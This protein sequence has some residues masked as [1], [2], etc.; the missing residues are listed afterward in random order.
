MQANRHRFV[1]LDRDGVIN[2]DSPAYIKNRDEFEFL[3]GSLQALK[4]L[5][6]AGFR[7]I[8][9]TNQSAVGRRLMTL[10]ELQAIHDKM[11]AAVRQH[12]GRIHDI[13]FCPHHPADACRCRKP[14]PGLIHRAVQKHAIDLSR[15]TMVGDSVKDIECA[16][17]AGCGR[18]VLVRTGNG[19]Q[20]EK[21]LRERGI[22]VEHVARDLDE[23][24]GWLIAQALESPD[25]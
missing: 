23:A 6:R 8:V 25:A 12:G 18:A 9:V 14:Q 7:L 20:A 4:N 19:I 22:A 17:N 15:A 24:A 13:F 10:Q 21:E 11:T 2:R 16:R 3:P 1:F 5:S